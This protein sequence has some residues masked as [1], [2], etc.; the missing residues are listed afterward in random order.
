[1]VLDVLYFIGCLGIAT[2]TLLFCIGSDDE[3]DMGRG[4]MD[5]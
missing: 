3:G 1:M 4:G 5:D 2:L